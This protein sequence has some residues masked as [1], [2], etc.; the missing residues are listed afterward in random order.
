M[1]SPRTVA[2][3]IWSFKQRLLNDQELEELTHEVMKEIIREGYQFTIYKDGK[4]LDYN[5]YTRKPSSVFKNIKVLGA[6]IK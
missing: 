2:N 4:L 5:P 1:Y 3:H 6:L